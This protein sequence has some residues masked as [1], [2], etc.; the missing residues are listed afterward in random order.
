MSQSRTAYQGLVSPLKALF[1]LWKSGCHNPDGMRDRSDVE[2]GIQGFG[3]L[4]GKIIANKERDAYRE[5][6]LFI[7]HRIDVEILLSCNA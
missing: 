4:Y 5:L 7:N 1:G 2:V 6:V 3:A